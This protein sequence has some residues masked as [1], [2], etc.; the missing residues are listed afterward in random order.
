ME[1][2]HRSVESQSDFVS[3]GRFSESAKEFRSDSMHHRSAVRGL[4][5]AIDL[6]FLGCTSLSIALNQVMIDWRNSPGRSH[7]Q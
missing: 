3:S 7:E 4:C 1:A 6:R 2:A 5:R